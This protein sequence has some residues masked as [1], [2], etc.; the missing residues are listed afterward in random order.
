[1]VTKAKLSGQR[2]MYYESTVAS[3]RE[4][5]YT[6]KGESAGRY[7]GAG[8]G[9]LGLSGE[10]LKGD[11][12]KLGQGIHPRTGERLRGQNGVKPGRECNGFDFTFNF[13]KSVSLL[14]ATGNDELQA[15]IR[16]A[17]DQSVR[18]GLAVLEDAARVRMRDG[19]RGEDGRKKL[20]SY[21]P[22]GGV[23][24]IDFAHRTNRLGHPHVHDHVP[25]MNLGQR[26]DGSWGA[27][28]FAP[29]LKVMMVAGAVQEA[30]FRARMSERGFTWRP[31][32]KN[33]LAELDCID[34]MILRHYSKRTAQIDEATRGRGAKARQ[35]A[36]LETRDVKRRVDI[37][38]LHEE[39]SAALGTDH[40]ELTARGLCRRELPR[41][42]ID[43]GHLAG[44]D[45]LTATK[46][47]F[48]HE[49]TLIAIARSHT[50]GIHPADLD[51]EV[52][53]FFARRDVLELPSGRFTV[54]DL[55]DAERAREAAQLGRVN[56]RT[57]VI[58]DSVITK[59]IRGF[60]LNDE[61]EAIVRA[62]LTSGRG[63]EQIEAEAG[64]GKTT[65][66]GAIRAVVELGGEHGNVPRRVIGTA[67]ADAAVHELRDRA[68]IKQSYNIRSLLWQLDHG[69]L[70]L[71]HRDVL[72]M[73]ERS[74][75][76]TRDGARV[77]QYAHAAGAKVVSI[78]DV[79]QL[80]AIAAGGERRGVHE[81]LG[82][83]KLT[84]VMRQ[85]DKEQIRVN[86]ALHESVPEPL[87]EWAE[88]KG[89]MEF[90]AEPRQAADAYQQDVRDVG[91]EESLLIAPTNAMVDHL[92]DLVR[93]DRLARGELGK[94]ATIGELTVSVGDR[95][96]FKQAGR[97]EENLKL[98][99]STRGTVTRIIGDRLEVQLDDGTTRHP[100]PSYVEDGHVRL[101]YALTGHSVQG[102][103]A[104]RAVLCGAPDQMFKEWLYVAVTRP[105]GY[106]RVF[107]TPLD[108]FGNGREDHGPIEP[109]PDRD[110]RKVA[111]AT[112]RESRGED[113][114]IDDLDR[115]RGY[116]RQRSLERDDGL[117]LS[118]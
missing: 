112:A 21:R 43:H 110:T 35:A 87:F 16:E 114:A 84:K 86:H 93:G 30:D 5:Y 113:L 99:N 45:G 36:A 98:I 29:M 25:I 58:S 75:I 15:A 12:E 94:E 56:E 71:G 10:L 115:G 64:T 101:G 80:Q 53:L 40:I 67:L 55:V 81:K 116:D 3:S 108:R 117:E 66:A 26:P 9:L 60:N 13:A 41:A 88:R 69:K 89:L 63:Y 42:E 96:V 49:D 118:L 68:G 19:E 34:P 79:G 62:S 11:L 20:T 57:C 90:D 44:P 22:V 65:T 74:M 73:D 85:S 51:A 33:G 111:I 2:L 1:M 38:A 48:T 95:V 77:E 32:G 27:L 31:L 103:T 72:I 76:G 18:A 61:Q 17:K 106:A 24:A 50:Q 8:A 83:L 52:D 54:Q 6:G 104:D 37:E 92:N 78:G 82:G 14:H 105:R 23:I 46:N 4:D 59:G 107:Y 97:D 39:V 109:P 28:D 47:T 102:A 7:L 91:Y 100:E 70:A